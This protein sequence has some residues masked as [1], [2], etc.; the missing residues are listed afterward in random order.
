M[1]CMVTGWYC[2]ILA[3]C[4]L[5]T[6][7]FSCTK[8]TMADIHVG[9][10]PNVFSY[11]W[12]KNVH[13]PTI[14][15]DFL[16]GSWPKMQFSANLLPFWQF[17]IHGGTIQAITFSRKCTDSS[18]MMVESIWQPG[19]DVSARV[20][21]YQRQHGAYGAVTAIFAIFVLLWAKN[22]IKMWCFFANPSPM[23]PMTTW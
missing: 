20:R 4:A 6:V 8:P 15:L 14:F 1:S 19:A 23:Y 11:I 2:W 5:F 3:L 13:L 21:P 12:K 16:L 7:F 9:C 22:L 18:N 10:V 17:F